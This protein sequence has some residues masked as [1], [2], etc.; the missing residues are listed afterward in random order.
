[1]RGN[2]ILKRVGLSRKN[3]DVV[4]K[5]HGHI[6]RACRK[7][8][9][10]HRFRKLSHKVKKVD[11]AT[12]PGEDEETIEVEGIHV[13][14]VDQWKASAPVFVTVEVE[15][16]LIKLEL[17][18]SSSSFPSAMHNLSKAVQTHTPENDHGTLEDILRGTA[19]FE[20]TNPCQSE[21][22]EDRSTVAAVGGRKP[23]T[24]SDG[25]ELAVQG[26]Y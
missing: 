20:R 26:A 10:D 15:G 11:E 5:L 3:A 1:M 13:I 22:R 7:K 19:V 17:Y 2:T 14:G 24:A 6:E 23:R 9:R 12:P 21:E 8:Q 18:W 25:S 4:T 16:Q